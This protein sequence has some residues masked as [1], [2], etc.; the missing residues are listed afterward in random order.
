MLGFHFLVQSQQKI[1]VKVRVL[2][3]FSQLAGAGRIPLEQEF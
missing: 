1:E 3:P 2:I